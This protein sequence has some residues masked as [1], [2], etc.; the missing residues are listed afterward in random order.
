MN[1]IFKVTPKND[2]SWYIKWAA[3]VILLTGMTLTSL[4]V[5]PFNLFFHLVG[6]SGWLVVGMLWH[7]RALITINSVG[8]FIF[9][10]GIGKYYIM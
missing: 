10:T 5:A 7:D 6:V 4:E 3:T 9:L 1:Q 8:V 2:L